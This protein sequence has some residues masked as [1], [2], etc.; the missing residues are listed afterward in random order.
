MNL[1]LQ[2]VQDAEVHFGQK[3]T[4]APNLL[5]MVAQG[6]RAFG[7]LTG[8]MSEGFAV[9]VGT[10]NGRIR[11]AAFNKRTGEAWGEGDLRAVLA[12]IGPY[13]NWTLEKNADFFDY[14]EKKNKTVIAEATGWQSPH[15]RY[16]FAYIPDVAGEVGLVPDRDAIDRKFGFA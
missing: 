13:A 12:Q 2:T 1:L 9:T 3:A 16:A 4:M 5:G 14:E 15:R 7:F 11:Y 10:F 8:D 6:E